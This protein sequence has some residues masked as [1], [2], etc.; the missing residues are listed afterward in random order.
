[1]KRTLPVVLLAASLAGCSYLGAR[2]RDLGDIVRLEGSV[3]IGVQAYANAGELVHAGAGST[4]R[5][6]AGWNYGELLSER[7]QEDHLPLSLLQSW[8]RPDRPALH[9][10]AF[11]R[12]DDLEEAADY[13]VLPG[14]L[15]RGTV[16]R[17]KVHYWNLEAGLF[18]GVAGLEAGI[19]LGELADFL[20]GLAGFDLAG[21]DSDG[22]RAS[23]R[24]WV[25]RPQPE[26]ASR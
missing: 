20:V 9:R 16:E 24:T 26:G 13:L 3:G 6:T 18:L 19:S 25:D 21:D 11:G 12:G 5:W 8:V 10:L 14:E 22:G 2:L 17:S 1:M 7:R 23:R 15:N 4:R